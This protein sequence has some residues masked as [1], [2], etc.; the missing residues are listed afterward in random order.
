[1]EICNNEYF[2]WV[3]FF[4]SEQFQ[5]YLNALAKNLRNKK[6]ILYC[7]GL[8]FDALVDSCNLKKKFNVIGISDI[9]YE[10]DNIEIYKG[11]KCIKPS[12]IKLTKVNCVV[13]TSPN[14]KLIAKYL[15]ESNNLSFGVKI[16]PVY[17]EDE[18]IFSKIQL[19]FSY[20]NET[21]NLLKAMQYLLFCNNEELQVKINYAKVLKKIQGYKN[22][23]IRV[24]FVCEENQKWAYNLIY[25]K[26][27]EEDNFEVLPVVLY[28]I[29]TKNRVEFTQKNN[30]EFFKKQNIETIDGYDYENHRN[31][32]I[33]VYEPDIVFYE[34]PWYLQ[35][36]NNPVKVS[37]FALTILLPY[38][39][40]TLNPKSWGSDS[41][42]RVYSNLWMFFSESPYHNKFYEKAANMLGKDNLCAVGSAKFDAYKMPIVKEYESLWK[43]NGKRIIIAPH[44]SINNQ[45]LGMGNFE[46]YYKFFLDFAKEHKEFSFI[47]KPHPALRSSCIS[48]KFMTEEEYDNYIAEWKSLSNAN[49]YEAGNYFE[50]FKTSDLMITDCSSFLA[51]Y[52][53]TNK[54]IIL[55]DRKTRA[56]FDN[57]GEKIKKGFYIVNAPN[58]LPNL[59]N[60]LLIINND[61][62]KPVRNKIL[63]KVFYLPQD[64]VSDSIIKYIKSQVENFN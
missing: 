4:K 12:R 58:E 17:T 31:I 44:H 19:C 45:G 39:Y 53:P 25:K 27:L 32:P 51:E 33:K 52:Y 59:I 64:F 28:P 49:V 18:N 60:E 57:F 9:R 16:L 8:Y 10:N 36:E 54:P 46:E 43:G 48:A 56:K 30:I 42:K 47:L 2:Y 23:K 63:N 62:L 22:K 41:V 6:I 1:M 29:V 14:P 34:Q 11:F 26:L 35:G 37:E 40:T 15:K 50:I 61:K 24:L 20:F 21:K 38:G 13:I 7:N 5:K 55:L 3:S